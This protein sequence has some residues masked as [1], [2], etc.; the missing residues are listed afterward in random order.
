[1]NLFRID[2]KDSVAVALKTIATGETNKVGDIEVTANEEIKTGHKIALKNIASGEPVIKYGCMIGEAAQEIQKGDWVHTHNLI[3]HADDARSYTYHFDVNEVVMPGTSDLTFKGYHRKSGETG[4]R[5]YIAVMSGVFCA[6][7]HM[8]QFAEA[9]NKR[10]PKN[11][12]FDGFLPLTH[13]CGCGQEGD[14]LTNV[15][16]IL[17]NLMQ[18]PNF[19]GVLLVQVGCEINRFETIEP[20][21]D[22]FDY[23]RLRMF[24]MQEV[25]DGYEV[26]MQYAEELYQIAANDARTERPISELHIGF[27]CGGSDGFSGLTANKLLGEFANYICAKGATATLTEVT[28]M[29]GAEQILMNRAIDQAAFERIKELLKR[30]RDYI[31][32]YGGTA[33]GNPSFGNKAGGISTIEDKS[34]GCIQKGGRCAI[35]DALF[36][37]ER[38]E[39][40]GLNLVQGPGS[41]L[42]G[43]TSQI[44]AGAT[45]EI[46]TT[47]RGTPVAFAAPTLKV[48]TN[49]AIYEKKRNWMDFNAG[50]L[51]EGRTMEELRKEFIE[52]V[53]KTASGEYAASNERA[54]FYE[55]GILRDGVIL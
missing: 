4:T 52:L 40:R 53:L 7:P 44:A 10:F 11:E 41:D 21:L 18:N 1:M 34:L 36:Y 54:G 55:I 12:H 8:K 43:V 17:A 24:T 50:Q 25:D 5:N 22:N 42:V 26:A 27:N 29:F 31:L 20:Y 16:R 19:G 28:E 13:E 2:E 23:D 46:F 32:K 48:S 6:N 14:D 3:S 9:A 51:L 45:M 38:V 30:H 47:G 49:S 35:V 39:K 37:G 33:N 15:R